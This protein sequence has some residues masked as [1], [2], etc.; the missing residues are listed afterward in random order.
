MSAFALEGVHGQIARIE[1]KR[2]VVKQL[3]QAKTI[4]R[5]VRGY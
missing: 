2:Q 1:L 5:N 4:T 3:P